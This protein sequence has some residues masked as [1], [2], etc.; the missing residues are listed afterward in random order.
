MYWNVNADCDW[1]TFAPS[2]GINDATVTVY[3]AANP[4]PSARICRITVTASGASGSPHELNVLQQAGGC[5]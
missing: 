5:R 1:V 4:T 2:S 3:I